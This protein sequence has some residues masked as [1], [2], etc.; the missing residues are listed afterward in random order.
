MHSL[1][2]IHDILTWARVHADY[3][4]MQI[5]GRQLETHRLWVASI[6]NSFDIVIRLITLHALYT[7]HPCWCTVFIRILAV[8]T[9]YPW[10]HIVSE[11][12]SSDGRSADGGVYICKSNI[13]CVY[14]QTNYTM[15]HV[16]CIEFVLWLTNM[17]TRSIFNLGRANHFTQ[18]QYKRT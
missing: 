2:K 4:L 14:I 11:G 17:N 1:I 8:Y 15:H 3:T 10:Y 12:R 16:P 5:G 9:N 6:A 18:Q 7:D 13:D